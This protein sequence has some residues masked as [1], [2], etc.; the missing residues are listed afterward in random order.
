MQKLS[1]FVTVMLALSS[2]VA[3][4]S[5]MKPVNHSD[6]TVMPTQQNSWQLGVSGLYLQP[7]FGGNGL[8]YS[9]Y[10]NYGFDF[11]G[12]LIEVNGAT[13]YLSNIQPNRDWASEIFASYG[14]G[15]GNDFTLSWYHLNNNTNGT[16]PP[17]TLY[18][19]SA[20]A[21]YAGTLNIATR[22]D[23]VNAMVG[24]RINFSDNKILHLAVGLQWT[25]INP[26]FVNS[27]RITANAPAVFVTTDNISYTGIGPRVA[28]DF[29]Y[30]I[31]SGFGVYAKAGGTLLV[32][33]AKQSIYG[34]RNLGGFNLYSTGNYNQTN[35]SIVVPEVDAMLGMKYD[36]KTSHG[37]IGLD[38]G[39]LWVSY[40][41][42]IVSQVGSGVVSSAISNSV[43]TNFNMNGVACTLTLS[44]NI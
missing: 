29:S 35:N 12:N 38:V 10:S 18:A 23:A 44:G 6:T 43:S 41:N 25:D 1:K 5:N 30:I 33:T 15:S 13:N 14:F 37:V 19:G 11:A 16:L 17:G 22:W 2:S 39:Y 21:L 26:K 8:G 36:Y 40:I 32:G 3:F 34:Y 27:P 9:T 7:S 4:A 31:G 42:A 28:G 24:Q 20:S